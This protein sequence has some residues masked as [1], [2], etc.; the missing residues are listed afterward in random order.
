MPHSSTPQRNRALH[1]TGH[2]NSGFYS[3]AALLTQSKHRLAH[4]AT[5]TTLYTTSRCAHH[6]PLKSP[7]SV[8]CLDARVCFLM[9]TKESSQ[10]NGAAVSWM[11]GVYTMQHEMT[12]EAPQQQQTQLQ[13]ANSE[14][15]VDVVYILLHT[16]K[17]VAL[18][19]S[20]S[21][22]ANY[23]LS[24]VLSINCIIGIM[25]S[26]NDWDDLYNYSHK[27]V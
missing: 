4:T 10:A 26:G 8:D 17:H 18:F 1:L 2:V 16:F 21:K 27:H 11:E 14:S 24:Q 22:G 20:T 13:V 9:Q 12:A 5:N 6:T 7:K 23:Q 25:C 15:T 19:V 3:R